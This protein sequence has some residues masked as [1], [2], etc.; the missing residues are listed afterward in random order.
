M[1]EFWRNCGFQLLS[2][3]EDGFLRLQDDF[4]RA[5]LLRPELAPVEES[6]PDELRLHAALREQPSRAV[7]QKELAAL[8]DE[9]ARENYQLFLNFRGHLQAAD[10]IEHCYHS[11]FLPGSRIDFPPLFIDH[12]VQVILRGILEDVE[13]SFELRA[14]ELFFREQD[15]QNIA[16]AI[17]LTDNE[18]AEIKRQQRTGSQISLLEMVRTEA[19]LGP[20]ELEVLSDE[21]MA[22]YF[23]RSERYEFALDLTFGR[24]GLTAL[25]RVMERW[26]AHFLGVSVKI[27]PQQE[28]HDEQW[29]WHV[30][31]D[32][33][34]SALL[35]DLYQQ[36]DV[37]EAR[38]ER[39]IS[40][41]RLTFENSADM[42][43]DVAGRP[44]YLGLS[45]GANGRLKLKPQN[46]LVNLPL[47]T[48]A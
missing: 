28:I 35:N 6:C 42:R 34:A 4:L 23:G 39:L 22:K 29:T 19:V 1:G 48:S 24:R 33:D 44:V 46:L 10:N 2:R 36:K 3:D 38:I 45:A 15:V 21:N 13:D 17:L 12:L 30:G 16:G 20:A 26:I 9:D 8:A 32:A 14:A 31:L 41:F 11:L 43:G 27:E 18:A 5:Y 7:G 37:D 47:A 25:A 40:L